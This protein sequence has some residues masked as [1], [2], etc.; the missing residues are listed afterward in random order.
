MN[1]RLRAWTL[2]LGLGLLITGASGLY[3]YSSA[4]PN[5]ASTYLQN[6]KTS[7]R[8]LPLTYYTTNHCSHFRIDQA[9]G[10]GVQFDTLG[11]YYPAASSSDIANMAIDIISWSLVMAAIIFG[12]KRFTKVGKIRGKH[13]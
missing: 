13:A 4:D 11:D 6:H 10:L 8:G 3:A 2:V 1:K 7:Y 9:V 12:Y 5:C